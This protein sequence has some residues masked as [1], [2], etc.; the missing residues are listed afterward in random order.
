LVD[1]S[2]LVTRFQFYTGTTYGFN[3]QVGSFQLSYYQVARPLL[4]NGSCYSLMNFGPGTS[5]TNIAQSSSFAM[6]PAIYSAQAV[7]STGYDTITTNF[8]PSNIDG[9]ETLSLMNY[10]ASDTSKAFSYAYQG[11]GR[12]IR[13]GGNARF[14]NAG[15]NYPHLANATTDALVYLSPLLVPWPENVFALV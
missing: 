14:N 15:R 1:N 11:T 12:Y 2:Q 10:Y 7:A 6:L 5:S 9:T 3:S 13:I 4:V 8:M